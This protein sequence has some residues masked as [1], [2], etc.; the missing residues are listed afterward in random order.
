MAVLGS[1]DAVMWRGWARGSLEGEVATVE[2]AG[3]RGVA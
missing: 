3:K 2:L 1:S